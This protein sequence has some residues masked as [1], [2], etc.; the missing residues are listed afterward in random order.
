MRRQLEILHMQL[1]SITTQSLIK[2]LQ[3]NPAFDVITDISNHVDLI[4]NQVDCMAR[5][6][7]TITNY[8]IPLRMHV[9]TKE[10]IA[11]VVS[12]SKSDS[13]KIYYGLILAEKSVVGIIKND[14]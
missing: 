6:P 14:P 12:R 9:Q 10:K 3:F 13:K 2:T 4:H 1:I 7:F 5:D 8:F 11:N